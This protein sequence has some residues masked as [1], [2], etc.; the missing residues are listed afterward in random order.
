MNNVNRNKYP[1]DNPTWI[2]ANVAPTFRS[3]LKFKFSTA[4]FCAIFKVIISHAAPCGMRLPPIL[5]LIINAKY[6]G[7]EGNPSFIN[8]EIM[9][10]KISAVGV[11]ATKPEI[12]LTSNKITK[13][14]IKGSKVLKGIP[15]KRS[16]K[17]ASN[18][19]PITTY[20][21]IKKN[22][23]SHSTSLS[24]SIVFFLVNFILI[25]VKVNAAKAA[26][27][28]NNGKTAKRIMVIIIPTLLI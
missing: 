4:L 9:G 6:N 17:P 5:M 13:L 1:I 23:I 26:V 10:M 15:A 21:E 24:K 27:S 28:Y 3:R 2:I 11:F 16:S 20:N 14:T 12:K 8:N 22:M 25:R 18:K 7:I 19:H